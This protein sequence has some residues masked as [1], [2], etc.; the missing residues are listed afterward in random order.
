MRRAL[1]SDVHGDMKD[2]VDMWTMIGG[3]RRTMVRDAVRVVFTGAFHHTTRDPIAVVRDTCTDSGHL[4]NRMELAT[5]L[6]AL[7]GHFSFSVEDIDGAMLACVDKIRSFPLYYTTEGSAVRLAGHPDAFGLS[8]RDGD[9]DEDSLLEFAMAGYVTGG[10]TMLPRVR[11]L[12]AGE[13][14]VRDADGCTVET[15]YRFRDGGEFSHDRDALFEGLRTATET[16]FRGLIERLRGRPVLIPLSGGHDSRF[17]LCELKQRGYDR[18]MTF[19]YGVPGTFEAQRARIVA[20]R[21]GVPWRFIPYTRAHGRSFFRSPQYAGY[22]RLT[23]AASTI[24]FIMDLPALALLERVGA[25]PSDAVMMNGISGDFVTGNHIPSHFH[26][27]EEVTEAQWMHALI[28]RHYA[29]WRQLIPPHPPQW[30][31]A[32]IVA[33][34][35]ESLPDVMSRETASRLFERWDWRARQA[36]FVIHGQRAYEYM[37]R[38]WELPHWDDAFLRFWDRVPFNERFQQRLYRDY[39]MMTDRF[40]CFRTIPSTRFIAPPIPA[41]L[42]RCCALFGRHQGAI[43]HTLLSYWQD[44]AYYYALYP[45]TTYLRYARLH[46]SPISYHVRHVLE[47]AYGQARLPHVHA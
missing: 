15:Y 16:V 39:L 28:H 14:L 27:L 25:L 36:C 7:R 12:Q 9:R 26:G 24:P 3:S 5:A 34:L 33:V 30:M 45:Y 13:F 35:G 46:R 18:I 44:S 21:V 4:R 19:T 43:A 22:E 41:M 11:Q 38:S 31:R 10:N 32:R 42:Q 29:L 17:V 6:R 23:H 8:T 37:H 40:G 2:T 1:H 20:E 47:R